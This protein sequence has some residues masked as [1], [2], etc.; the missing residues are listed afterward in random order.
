M[1]TPIITDN[2]TSYVRPRTDASRMDQYGLLHFYFDLTKQS[3]HEKFSF[4]Y[5]GT[6][7]QQF[8]QLK[9]HISSSHRIYVP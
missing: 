3:I 7:K 9:K 5:L 2:M 6:I 8:A 4:I 1:G